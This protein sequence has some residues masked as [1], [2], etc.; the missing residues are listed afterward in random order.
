MGDVADFVAVSVKTVT[1][2]TGL[3]INQTRAAL[4]RGE[5]P[6]L[7]IVGGRQLVLTAPFLRWASGER[8]EW[9]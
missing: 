5:I 4:Q 8:L 2:L 6:G 9:R 7:T 1:R 3:G